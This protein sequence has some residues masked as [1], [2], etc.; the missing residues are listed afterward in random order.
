MLDTGI[1]GQSE[2]YQNNY[3]FTRNFSYVVAPKSKIDGH[4]KLILQKRDTI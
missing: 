3:P 2:A 1:L 4:N